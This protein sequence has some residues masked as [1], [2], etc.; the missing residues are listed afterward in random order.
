MMAKY[1]LATLRF[2]LS[3][4]LPS[5]TMRQVVLEPGQISV[6]RRVDDG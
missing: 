3:Y 4:I 5:E 1:R 2:L 6:F